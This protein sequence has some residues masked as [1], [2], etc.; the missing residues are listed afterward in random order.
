[1]ICGAILQLGDDFGDNACTVRCQLES[2]HEL[3]HRESF[4]RGGKPVIITWCV[5]EGVTFGTLDELST[6]HDPL[7]L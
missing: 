5:D 4:E 2:N 3:P 6:D 1:V 7:S